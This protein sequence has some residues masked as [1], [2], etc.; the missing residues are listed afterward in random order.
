[1][2]PRNSLGRVGIVERAR[3]GIVEQWKPWRASGGELSMAP[4]LP[5]AVSVRAAAWLDQPG[6][7]T[8]VQPERVQEMI[9]KC[10]ECDFT[11]K[12]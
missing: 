12:R 10:S 11:S 7:T 9:S 3:R 5:P 6:N 1:M 4:P 8:P 2:K